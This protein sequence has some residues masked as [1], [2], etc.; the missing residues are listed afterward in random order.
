MT[1]WLVSRLF[2]SELLLHR[3]TYAVHTTYP[4]TSHQIDFSGHAQKILKDINLMMMRT[5]LV[6]SVVE[7]SVMPQIDPTSNLIF[8]DG[9]IPT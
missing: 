8:V 5:H 4:W 6:D 9:T 7:H 2:Y 3:R 1:C